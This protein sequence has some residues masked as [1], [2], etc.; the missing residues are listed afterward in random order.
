MTRPLPPPGAHGGD[1]PLLAAALGIPESDVLDLSVSLNPNAPDVAAIVARHATSV[2]RYPDSSVARDALAAAMAV[3]PARVVLTNG[4]AEAIA[5]VAAHMPVGNVES[6]DFS[7]YERHLS[8]VQAGAPLW[9]SNPNNP[10][11]R[12]AGNNEYA[13]VWDEAFYP[14]ATGCWTR[15]DDKVI[16]VGSL[17]KVYACPG[18]RIGYVLAPTGDIARAIATRQS[19]WSVNSIACAVLPELLAATDLRG[20]ARSIALQ[21]VQMENLLRDHRLEPDPSDANY[22]LVRR[23]PGVRI[24]VARHGIVVRDTGSFGIA[25]GVRIAVPD[26]AGLERLDFALQGWDS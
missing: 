5:L 11:G 14:L 13:G 25:D 7:L 18:L 15:G 23:A 12:L 19:E 17:T 1:G 20:W 3:D 10:T 8:N 4:G 26:D 22:L 9:R 16:V 2:R 21:R 24:H 6:P